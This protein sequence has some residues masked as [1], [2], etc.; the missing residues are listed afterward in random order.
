MES[1][2]TRYSGAIAPSSSGFS[3]MLISAIHD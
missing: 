3:T 1:I 2:L